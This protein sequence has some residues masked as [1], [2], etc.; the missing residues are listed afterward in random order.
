MVVEHHSR[1]PTTC[2]RP[3]LT[4]GDDK[5]AENLIMGT[6]IPDG[7]ELFSAKAGL[8]N[9]LMPNWVSHLDISKGYP[10]PGVGR[11]VNAFGAEVG[12][13]L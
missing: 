3:E 7:V 12:F 6:D 8:L 11:A 13:L 5:V 1:P 10:N 2:L 4:V 9:L